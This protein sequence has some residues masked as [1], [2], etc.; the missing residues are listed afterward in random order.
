MKKVLLLG[1]V[2]FAMSLTS[3]KKDRNCVCTDEDGDTE[4]FTYENVNK[5]DAKEACD[6]QS[7]I[8]T[9]FGGG[10]CELE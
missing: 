4:S 7:T 1:G 10:S 6:A 5:S 8:W 3:C 2:V 9:A